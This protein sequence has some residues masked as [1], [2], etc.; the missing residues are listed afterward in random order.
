[1]REHVEP[2]PALKELF[3]D[4]F[5]IGAAVNPL[6]IRTQEPL[7]ARHFNSITAENEMKFVSLH[8]EE[9]NYTFEDADRLVDFAREHGMAMRGHTLVWHNQ[10]SDWLF[11]DRGGAP[12]SKA[13]LL[14]RMRE[15]IHTVVGRYKHDIYAWDVVNEAVADEGGDLLRASKWT[16]IAGPDLEFIVKAFE[17]AHEADPDAVLFYNDYNESHPLKRDKIYALAKSLLERGAPI[18]GIGLQAH[19]NLFDPSLDEIRAAIEKYA[20]LG[21]Q[22]QLTELDMSVFRFD[23]RRADL[24]APEPGMLERQAERYEAVFRLLKE[25]RDVISGVTFWGAADDYTWL[26][27]FPVQG[28]KNWPFLF[29]EQHSP[30]PAFDHVA[31]IALG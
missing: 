17:F 3:A 16:E 25:Y 22:M 31:G 18:H 11:Q 30:K 12:V 5:K 7:L 8:P 14:E 2:T 13:V 6:T 26:D 10:T 27:D 1:M 15:H 19:W 4:D 24:A 9:G 29:D 28:R 23:D 20:S 21:L